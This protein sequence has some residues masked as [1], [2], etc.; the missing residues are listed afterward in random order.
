VKFRTQDIVS[1]ISPVLDR[2]VRTLRL[3]GSLK[4]QASSTPIKGEDVVIVLK[5]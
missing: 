2:E 5:Q 1:A 3:T 4:S